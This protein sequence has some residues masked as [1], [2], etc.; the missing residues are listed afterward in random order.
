VIQRVQS[1]RSSFFCP[2]CQSQRSSR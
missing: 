1:E 2:Q